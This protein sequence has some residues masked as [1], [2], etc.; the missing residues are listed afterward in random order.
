MNY[1]VGQRVRSKAGRDRDREYVIISTADN[2]A[3][4]TDGAMR[5]LENPKKK[6]FRH[7]QGSYIVSEEIAKHIKDGTIENY[8]I[9]RFL[10]S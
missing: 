6:K 2:Y 10:N 9:R 7:I 3:Y 1:C 8:M 4:L 5:R